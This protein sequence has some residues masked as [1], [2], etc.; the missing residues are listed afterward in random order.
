MWPRGLRRVWQNS[1]ALRLRV[2]RMILKSLRSPLLGAPSADQILDKYIQALG[3]AQRL[4]GLSSYTGKGT[5]AGYDTDFGKIPAEVYASAGA[6]H[7]VVHLAGGDSTMAYDGSTGWIA[8]TNTQLPMVA[9][10][11]GDL[12][13]RHTGCQF[14]LPLQGQAIPQRACH[15]GFPPTDVDDHHDVVVVEGTAPQGLARESYSS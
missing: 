3:G 13:R 15:V 5:Y 9:L 7:T 4:A 10:T 6:A 2:I 8:A 12:E 14:R 1:T 11:G